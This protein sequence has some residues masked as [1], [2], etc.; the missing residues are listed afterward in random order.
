M[1]AQEFAALCLPASSTLRDAMTALN[2]SARGVLMVLHEDGSLRRTLTDGDLRR[3]ALA[4]T[5]DSA[6]IAELPGQPPITLHQDA[7][8]RKS[9]V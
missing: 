8:D 9:V 2:T 7:G 4:H 6:R 1:T 5:P 3:A